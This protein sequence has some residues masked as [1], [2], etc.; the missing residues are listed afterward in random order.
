MHLRPTHINGFWHSNGI[1]ELE[2]PA[3][4]NK[5]ME[6]VLTDMIRSELT[7]GLIDEMEYMALKE[8]AYAS[9][10]IEG[11]VY[12][13]QKEVEA[14]PVFSPWW[15]L[16]IGALNQNKVEK[17]EDPFTETNRHKMLWKGIGLLSDLDYSQETSFQSM[18]H[19]SNSVIART[20]GV[21]AE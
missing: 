21:P 2:F 20:C 3:A 9:A 8:S 4:N 5:M 19:P 13:Q 7:D 14:I 18:T 1:S 10:I 16:H 6:P 17:D 15:L 11:D 12:T